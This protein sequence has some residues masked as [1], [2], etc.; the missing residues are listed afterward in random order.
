MSKNLILDKLEGVKNRFDEVGRLINEPETIADMNRYVKLNKEYKDLE[1]VIQ[2]YEEYKNLLS[3]IAT[4]KDM[5]ATEKDEEMR[6]MAKA[7][8]DE[9]NEKVSP[10]E[11][12]IK[13]LL[14]PSDPE[15][16]KDALVEIRAGTGGDEASIFA[17]ELYRMYTKFCETKKWKLLKIIFLSLN[18]LVFP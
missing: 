9:L 7:E 10:L 14:I 13:F 18:K 6:E 5:L 12:N 11:E 4:A 17:G 8:L 2:A 1:P 3:N 15:D 16:E